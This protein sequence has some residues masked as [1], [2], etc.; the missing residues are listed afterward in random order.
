MK[1]LFYIFL[2][3][4]V[5][6]NSQTYEE[7]VIYKYLKINTF[8]ILTGTGTGTGF[9]YNKNG[10]QYLVTNSHVCGEQKSLLIKDE[11]FSI[12]SQVLYTSLDHDIC[13]LKPLKNKYGINSGKYLNNKEY[14]TYGFPFDRP[15]QVG[16]GIF[17]NFDKAAVFTYLVTNQSIA[18]KCLKENSVIQHNGIVYGCIHFYTNVS[19]TK[20]LTHP[21]QSGS[22]VLNKFGQLVGVIFSRTGSGSEGVMLKVETLN[23]AIKEY[24]VLNGK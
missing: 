13:L 8:K 5:F 9:I 12:E 7:L 21:G 15:G 17:S 20:L 11:N 10:K 23:E 19:L 14:F 4:F 6:F 18:N 24:E 2:L 22:P 1:F 16:K 3:L